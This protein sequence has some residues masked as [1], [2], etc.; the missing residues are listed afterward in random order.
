MVR[1]KVLP[2]I[3][4]GAIIPAGIQLL[5]EKVIHPRIPSQ[6][7]HTSRVIIPVLQGAAVRINQQLRARLTLNQ[8]AVQT[9]G[10]RLQAGRRVIVTD[11]QHHRGLPG[12]ATGPQRHRG[13][14]GQAT[15]P[16]HPR[17][18]ADPATGLRLR[19]QD[20]RVLQYHPAAGRPEV[21]QDRAG[22]GAR[23]RIKYIR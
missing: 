15:G 5:Q 9:T 6:G 23:T 14:P 16:L 12:Q 19:L 10:L 1:V 7:Q 13:L 2:G 18:R 20:L 22:A 8:G 11:P 21:P 17:D 3:P 4:H